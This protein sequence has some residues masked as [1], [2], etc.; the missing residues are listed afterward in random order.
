MLFQIL[1]DSFELKVAVRFAMSSS[2]TLLVGPANL[3]FDGREV[4]FRLYQIS[5][6]NIPQK[7]MNLVAGRILSSQSTSS[8]HQEFD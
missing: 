7:I 5:T 8:L 4:W 6:R 2:R 1:I 3:L